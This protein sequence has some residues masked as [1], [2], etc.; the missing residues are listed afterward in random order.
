MTAHKVQGQTVRNTY[1]DPTYRGFEKTEAR[2]MFYTSI[3]RP[4]NKLFVLS[5]SEYV[6]PNQKNEG[7]SVDEIFSP[8]QNID[9]DLGL[10][11]NLE[12]EDFKCKI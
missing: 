3:T 5:D 6:D 8:M 11:T 4:T 7:I 1:V 9:F 12:A 10:N 2:R